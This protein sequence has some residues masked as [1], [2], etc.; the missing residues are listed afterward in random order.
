MRHD[1]DMSTVCRESS[2][3]NKNIGRFKTKQVKVILKNSVYVKIS[4]EYLL[5]DVCAC[6]IYSLPINMLVESSAV[7][8]SHSTSI[9]DRQHE[10]TETNHGN[11][12]TPSCG[13]RLTRTL[14][15]KT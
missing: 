15:A 6:K 14:R 3:L 8:A 10:V 13:H 1:A 5:S 4:L 9:H 7:A 12:Q 11:D 2:K